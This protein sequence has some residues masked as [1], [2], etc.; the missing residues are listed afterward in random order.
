MTIRTSSKTIAWKTRISHGMQDNKND[1]KIFLYDCTDLEQRLVHERVQYCTHLTSFVAYDTVIFCDGSW[2][3][4]MLECWD[5]LAAQTF[6]QWERSIDD[7]SIPIMIMI[8]R[9]RQSILLQ[10]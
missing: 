1:E 4:C 9:Q 8:S 3:K 7:F 5:R 6:S 10:Y 2:R